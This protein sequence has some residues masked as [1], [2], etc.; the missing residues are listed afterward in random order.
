MLEEGTVKKASRHVSQGAGVRAQAGERTG[1]AHT[2]DISL[3]NLEEAA[4]Q[5]R[6]IAE[7]RGDVGGAWP[8]AGAAARTT[9]TRVAEPPDRVPTSRRKVD[10]LARDRRRRARAPIRASGR[11]SP[12]SRSEDVRDPDRHRR[13]AG[14]WA[15]CGRSRGS[16]SPCIAEER[17]RARDRPYGGGGRVA[18]R[19]LPGGRA[20]AA[21]R[22]RG[23]A[24]GRCSSSTRSMRRRAAMTVVLG[25]GLARHPAPRGR[26]P[27]ARGRLQPQGDLGLRRPHRPAGRLRAVH[28]GRRRH[29]SPTGAARSTSTTRARRPRRNV[30]IENGVL[31][32][33][34][35]GPPERA[36]HGH[37]A[38]R[39]RPARVLRAPADAAH[40][41]HLH[42]RRRRTTP[43]RSSARSSAAS[44][45]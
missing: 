34:P 41:Q 14:R 32:R 43:R 22:A 45:R 36:A 17:R 8:C 20:L 35:A 24:A 19:L 33:L 39:Q 44:T 42:A 9:S 3:D 38:H 31:A 1:Y 2:D 15:T 4:R 18:V 16:T 28:G 5:A 21:L 26:R 13:P 30:L 12:A 23:G 7:Q 10:L 11:S 6:A 40:D 29:A 37:A 27:R 25:P